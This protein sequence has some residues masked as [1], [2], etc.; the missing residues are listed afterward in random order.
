MIDV[1]TLSL[2]QGNAQNNDEIPNFWKGFTQQAKQFLC[3]SNSYDTHFPSPT[4]TLI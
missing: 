2:F 1:K 3:T 4:H